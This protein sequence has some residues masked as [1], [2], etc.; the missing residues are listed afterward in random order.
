[1]NKAKWKRQG[2]KITN[3]ERKWFVGDIVSYDNPKI[4]YK[5]RW[6]ICGVTKSGKIEIAPMATSKT[7]SKMPN[8]H[9]LKYDDCLK[10]HPD[11]F[12]MD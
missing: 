8:T 4:L 12:G 3:G 9:Y 7:D 5:G 2:M 6:V 1:M 10:H 11:P